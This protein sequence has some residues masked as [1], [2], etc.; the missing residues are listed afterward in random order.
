MRYV[1][2]DLQND[3]EVKDAVHTWLHAQPKTF[4]ADGV[5]RITDRNNKC[6]ETLGDYVEK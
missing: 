4:L 2:A 6:V 1:D 5:R 3:R